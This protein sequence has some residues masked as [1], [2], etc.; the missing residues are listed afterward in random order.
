MVLFPH[1]VACRGAE[2][3]EEEGCT[4]HPCRTLGKK[5]Q[6]REVVVIVVGHFYPRKR[7]KRIGHCQKGRKEK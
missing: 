2:E 4:A 7:E 6:Q 5:G 3:G 1:C